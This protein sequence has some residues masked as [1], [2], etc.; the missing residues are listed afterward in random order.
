MASEN[1]KQIRQIEA[2]VEAAAER[3]TSI[4]EGH[5]DTIAEKDEEWANE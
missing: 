5:L 2:M 3:E 1:G 4:S